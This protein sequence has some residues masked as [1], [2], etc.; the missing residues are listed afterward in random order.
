[1]VFVIKTDGKEAFRSK[2]IR[3]AAKAAYDLNVTDVKTLELAVENGA[4][5]NGNDW[6]L[7]LEPMLYRNLVVAK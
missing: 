7:W 5:G 6:G 1:V 2:V 3:G 4:S